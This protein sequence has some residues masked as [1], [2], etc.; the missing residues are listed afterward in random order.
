LCINTFSPFIFE[1]KGHWHP[2]F[3]EF[4]AKVLNYNCR[5][6][7]IPLQA[8]AVY[9]RRRI[10]IVL[11][12]VVARSVLSKTKRIN[13]PSFFDESNYAGV[14]LDEV[15][16]DIEFPLEEFDSVVVIPD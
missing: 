7:G 10:S 3:K 15:G 2:E 16:N 13:S 6:S 5:N 9:W 14:I 4:F 8:L 1:T 12:K 11:Q